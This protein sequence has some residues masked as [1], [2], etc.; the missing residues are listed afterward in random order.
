M[1]S[2]ELFG[3]NVGESVNGD[4][5]LSALGQAGFGIVLSMRAK[6]ALLDRIPVNSGL[7]AIQLNAFVC[8]NGDR[9]IQVWSDHRL[10][11]ADIKCCHE[12]RHRLT[13][14]L[15]SSSQSCIRV[16]HIAICHRWRGSIKGC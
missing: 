10:P 12:N 8:V 6:R 1:T 4:L 15:H 2:E 11:L 7:H 16:A 13:G 5:V 3:V 9:L 14:C